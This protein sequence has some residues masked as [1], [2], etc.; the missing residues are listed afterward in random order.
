MKAHELMQ[1]SKEDLAVKLTEARQ[2]LFSV[3]E[4]IAAGKDKNHA[5]LKTLKKEVARIQTCISLTSRS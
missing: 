4:E 5:Q 2:K 3:R 1:L